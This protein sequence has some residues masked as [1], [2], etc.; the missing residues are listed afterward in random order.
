MGQYDNY[1]PE[2]SYDDELPVHPDLSSP[3]D[4]KRR[5]HASVAAKTVATPKREPQKPESKKPGTGDW[6]ND[7]VAA[8]KSPTTR[9]MFRN[10]VGMRHGFISVLRLSHISPIA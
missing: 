3:G 2:I 6:F 8:L 1:T 5:V 10:I 4:E 7:A 9:I